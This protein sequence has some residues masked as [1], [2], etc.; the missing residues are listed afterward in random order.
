MIKDR[1][2]FLGVIAALIMSAY[3]AMA[4]MQ[5]IGRGIAVEWNP[6][7]SQLIQVNAG[8]FFLVKM[9]ITASCLMVCYYLSGHRAARW[10]IKLAL[11]AYFAVCLY[12][13]AIAAFT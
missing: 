5:H 11:A 2:L 12:H 10:G 6:L 1:K 13:V 4:T 9:V 7:M 3:D 8:I